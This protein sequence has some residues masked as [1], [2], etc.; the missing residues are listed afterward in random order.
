MRPNRLSL[1]AVVAI[2]PIVVGFSPIPTEEPADRSSLLTVEGIVD[3][4]ETR[5]TDEGGEITSVRLRVDDPDARELDVLLAPENALRETGFEIEP[6]DRMRARIFLS[7]APEVEAHKV[8]NLSRGMMVRLRTL[9]KVPLW[10]G[11]GRW[12]G[13]PCRDQPGGGQGR[14]HRHRG[15]H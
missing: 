13:G 8:M 15:Q 2:L 5:V 9:R 11:E 12:Q 14:Q 3:A 1:I 4:V 6:G 7:D 10:D